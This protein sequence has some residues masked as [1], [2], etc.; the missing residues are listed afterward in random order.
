VY[1]SL[2]ETYS[3]VKK[4]HLPNEITYLPPD[5]GEHAPL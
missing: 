4:R 3:R 1:N 5:T 2:W